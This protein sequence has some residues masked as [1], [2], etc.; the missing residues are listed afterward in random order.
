MYIVFILCWHKYF[1]NFFKLIQYYQKRGENGILCAKPGFDNHKIN[2]VGTY[3]KK[4]KN[5]NN[6][7]SSILLIFTKCL[8]DLF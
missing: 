4:K 6:G 7:R 3:L 1:R 5:N 2:G 8:Y